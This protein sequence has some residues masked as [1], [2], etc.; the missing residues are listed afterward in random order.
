MKIQTNINFTRYLLPM[1]PAT[2]ISTVS[3]K[4]VDNFAVYATLVDFSYSPPMVLFASNKKKYAK[5]DKSPQNTYK[6]ITETKSF[7]VNVPEMKLVSKLKI[8]GTSFSRKIDKIKLAGLTKVNPFKLNISPAFPKLI[9]ECISH[10]ECKLVKIIN[11]KE[12]DHVIIIGKV[13]SAS[14]DSKLVKNFKEARKSLINKVFNNLGA[15]NNRQRLIGRIKPIR[16]TCPVYEK[17]KHIVK[18]TLK[19]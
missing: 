2:F 18:S 17:E 4:K 3:K 12:A 6:N 9:N 13:V 15:I 1:H 5:L 14:Y 19:G 8:G 7:I 10:L 16:V 11:I